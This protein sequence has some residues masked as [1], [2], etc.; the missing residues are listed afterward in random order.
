MEKETA[1]DRRAVAL[2]FVVFLVAGAGAVVLRG[3]PPPERPV[4]QP[5][6]FNHKKHVKDLD[7]ACT[8]C[9]AFYEKESFS[10]LPGADV[11]ASCHAEAQGKSEEE[12]KLVKLLGSGAA[13][14]WKPLFRQPPHVAYSHRR[15]VVVAKLECASCHG[16]VAETSVPPRRVRRLAMDDCVG[17]HLEKGVST[18]CTACHR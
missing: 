8:T 14:T 17:C 1:F 15:H 9:H 18:D 6:E 2:G 13:L 11:C 5:I 4:D 7:L 16:A 10:G 12:A 3:G